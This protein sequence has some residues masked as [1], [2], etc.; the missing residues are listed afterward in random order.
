MNAL[1][2]ALTRE[3][4]GLPKYNAVDGRGNPAVRGSSPGGSGRSYR[5]NRRDPDSPTYENLSNW[6]IRFDPGAGQPFT[7]YPTR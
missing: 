2:E 3:A 1:N 7:G 5:P 6:I 4:R